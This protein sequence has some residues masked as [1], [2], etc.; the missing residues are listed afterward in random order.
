MAT[1]AGQRDIPIHIFP[2][3]P[4]TSRPARARLAADS[5]ARPDLAAFWDGLVPGYL[6]FLQTG[7]LPRVV[8]DKHGAYKL[9][10]RR[11][12]VGR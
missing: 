10:P 3:R 7:A 8:A 11:A 6:A 12:S 5:A 9:E 2:C 4:S 1:D